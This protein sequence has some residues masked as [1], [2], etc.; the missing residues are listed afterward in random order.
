MSDDNELVKLSDYGL[1]SAELYIAKVLEAKGATISDEALWVGDFLFNYN[2]DL[3]GIYSGNGTIDRCIK[4]EG[5]G[6]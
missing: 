4:A 6:R 3:V 1:T 2:G 5:N